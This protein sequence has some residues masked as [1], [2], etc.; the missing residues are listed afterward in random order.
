VNFAV[1]CLASHL[2][3]EPAMR[4]F[5]SVFFGSKRQE[6]PPDFW[7]SLQWVFVATFVATVQA[8]GIG[9]SHCVPVAPF[10]IAPI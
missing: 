1:H 2:P 7:M 5:Q 9:T 4:V 8:G 10:L 6:I 3:Q